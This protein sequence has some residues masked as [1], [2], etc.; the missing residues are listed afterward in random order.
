MVDYIA[1]HE[2]E[3]GFCHICNQNQRNNAYSIQPQWIWLEKAYCISL[4]NREKR[5]K[6]AM[7]E[8]HRVGLCSKIIFYITEKDSISPIRGCWESHR[9]IAKRCVQENTDYYLVFEDDVFFKE[10][11]SQYH[12]SKIEKCLQTIPKNWNSL[13]W[14][15]LPKYLWYY[16][17]KSDYAHWK[18]WNLHAVMISKRLAKHFANHSFDSVNHSIRDSAPIEVDHWLSL[19]GSHYIVFPP[20]A[21]TKDD[22][23]SDLN[24][25]RS[26]FIQSLH[27][28]KNKNGSFIE[29][30]ICWIHIIWPPF[31]AL[32]VICA[33]V[34]LIYICIY[35]TY[36]FIKNKKI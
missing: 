35:Y 8:F 18:G 22:G 5:R 9:Q 1:A 10:N 23:I 27:E 3:I 29:E 6:S 28:W 12:V 11:F 4:K 16:N 2:W 31:L 34:Y 14:G 20:I 7:E 24:A 17:F 21:L 26:P 25:L 15:G 32:L 30:T 33:V 36:R 13:Y 19:F